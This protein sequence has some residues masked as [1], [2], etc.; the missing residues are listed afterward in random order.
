MKRAV[1]FFLPTIFS[2]IARARFIVAV[3]RGLWSAAADWAHD[4]ECEALVR[5]VPVAAAR[6]ALQLI[7]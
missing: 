2:S 1:F 4:H 3:A 6:P 7:K 5:Q